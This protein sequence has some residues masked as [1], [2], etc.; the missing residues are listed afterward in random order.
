MSVIQ[1]N[2]LTKKYKNVMV[3]NHLEFSVEKGEFFAFWAKMVIDSCV[4][5]MM[6]F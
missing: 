2:K 5:F 6:L 3:V 4:I 1:L